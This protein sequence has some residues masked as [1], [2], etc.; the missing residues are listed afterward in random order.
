M[1]KRVALYTAVALMFSTLVFALPGSKQFQAVWTANTEADLAGYFLYWRDP[2]GA[3][4]D[5]D[6]VDCGLNTS[7]LLTGEVPNKT[8]LALTAYDTSGNESEFSSELPFDQDS[9]AP[10]S[11]NG[12]AIQRVP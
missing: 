8:V 4:N 9:Q 2:S 7:Q 11:P 6:K 10:N 12:F 3:F 1:I 5:T